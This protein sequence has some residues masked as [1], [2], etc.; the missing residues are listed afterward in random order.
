[1]L[2]NMSGEQGGGRR[3]ATARPGFLPS[4]SDRRPSLSPALAR[5]TMGYTSFRSEE[6]SQP[7]ASSSRQ[8]YPTPASSESEPA[9]PT[10]GEATMPKKR[11]RSSPNPVQATE[12]KSSKASGSAGPRTVSYHASDDELEAAEAGAPATKL[13]RK[14]SKQQLK[15]KR[16]KSRDGLVKGAL[17][18]G[19]ATSAEKLRDEK[20][21]LM[22]TR[23]DL[24]I[25]AGE[26]PS[27]SFKL[28]APSKRT[29]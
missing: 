3:Q 20:Q 24:P 28:C 21:R 14:A 26:P 25:W 16:R 9:P 10:P 8:P 19:E 7:V 6:D 2:A 22:A 4:D 29:R 23:Q 18:P 27:L 13:S 17:A 1:M 11:R 12:I 5:R 15:L